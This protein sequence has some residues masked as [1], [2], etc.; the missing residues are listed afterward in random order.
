MDKFLNSF[1]LVSDQMPRT[2]MR[3]S[4]YRTQSIGGVVQHQSVRKRVYA[5]GRPTAGSEIQKG[6]G[7]E[8][9][10]LDV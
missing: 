2:A 1:R 8:G 6:V 10:F 7:S 9:E 5:S 4:D 3:R